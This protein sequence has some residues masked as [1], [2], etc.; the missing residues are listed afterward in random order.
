MVQMRVAICLKNLHQLDI[1]RHTPFSI[2][3]SYS[4]NTFFN[5]IMYIIIGNKHQAFENKVVEETI[6]TEVYLWLIFQNFC[7]NC[8]N[9]LHNL[10]S[11]RQLLIAR[12]ILWLIQNITYQ[13]DNAIW[14]NLETRSIALL[15]SIL[16]YH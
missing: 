12:I 3:V 14:G 6:R 5:T 1:I 11:V 13:L 4:K 15:N 9:Y 16:Y 2:S 8:K 10:L 7:M